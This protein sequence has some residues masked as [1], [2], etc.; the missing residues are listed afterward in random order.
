MNS[1][2]RRKFI[3]RAAILGVVLGAGLSAPALVSA[4]TTTV[5][6]GESQTPSHPQL[7]MA[8]RVAK[9]VKEKTGGRIDIQVFPNSQLGSNKEIG[10]AHV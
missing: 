8:E 3:A 7:M 10:R 1:I 9:E 5:R 4:Q 6:W 2:F